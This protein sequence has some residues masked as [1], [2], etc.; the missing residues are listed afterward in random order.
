[1]LDPAPLP[2]QQ[3]ANRVVRWPL[4]Y[5]WLR[6]AKVIH[7]KG[8]EKRTHTARDGGFMGIGPI[9]IETDAQLDQMYT[10][11]A[12]SVC[13]GDALYLIEYPLNNTCPLY[14]DLDFLFAPT[15]DV[16]PSSFVPF[17]RSL[18]HI[19]RSEVFAADVDPALFQL[20][21]LTSGVSVKQKGNQTLHKIGF[22]PTF[23]RLQVDTKML[24][25]IR[26]VLLNALQQQDASRVEISLGADAISIPFANSWADII[27]EAVMKSPS[28]RMLFSRKLENCSCKSKKE[29]CEHKATKGV[30]DHGKPYLLC[31]VITGAGEVDE[32]E[33]QRL[34]QEAHMVELLK[35]ASL[36]QQKPLTPLRID[37][38]ALEGA[39]RPKKGKA[40]EV[41]G[42]GSESM[43]T[44]EALLHC[45]FP[46]SH[47]ALSSAQRS[48]NKR[49]PVVFVETTSRYCFNKQGE[50]N[51][52]RCFLTVSI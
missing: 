33:T 45:M 31:Q 22:H 36:L 52:R 35:L 41:M 24:P 32:A 1:M 16:S 18:Q 12:Q 11:Y 7:R 13:N 46:S 6:N 4:L 9:H 20:L 29:P 50:H 21:V 8:Y 26:R 42:R 49:Q 44:M 43:D 15:L 5:I 40:W 37:E 48:R 28:S 10:E 3:L 17:F 30:V 34:Q 14:F 39:L 27:D 23:P 2:Y 25:A 19:L 51:S 47:V 38:N